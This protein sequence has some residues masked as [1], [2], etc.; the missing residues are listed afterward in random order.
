MHEIFKVEL[1][2][3]KCMESEWWRE[4]ERER[5]REKI[6]GPCAAVASV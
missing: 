2:L 3:S 5:K 4:R 1:K 6:Y